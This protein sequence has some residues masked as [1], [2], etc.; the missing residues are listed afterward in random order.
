MHF[1]PLGKKK[2]KR[3]YFKKFISN[4][5]FNYTQRILVKMNEYNNN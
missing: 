5:S 1:T 2:F 3:I 4:S